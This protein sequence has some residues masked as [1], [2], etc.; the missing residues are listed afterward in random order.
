M[1]VDC[2]LTGVNREMLHLI[3]YSA[4]MASVPIVWLSNY[5]GRDPLTRELQLSSLNVLHK[6]FTPLQLLEKIQYSLWLGPCAQVGSSA[7]VFR[8]A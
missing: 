4:G 6:P 2:S 1:L 3:Q 7:V 5:G 8:S